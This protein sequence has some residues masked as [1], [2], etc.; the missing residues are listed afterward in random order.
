MA[1]H[2]SIN[3][4]Y[5]DIYPD[6]ETVNVDNLLADIPTIDALVLIS[7]YTAML[8]T[9]EK[10]NAIQ[11]EIV[12]AWYGRFPH[13]IKM[14][15]ERQIARDNGPFSSFNYFNNV[16]SSLLVQYLLAHNNNRY[17]KSL[18]PLQEENLFKAYL[19]FSSQWTLEQNEFQ[20]KHED[21]KSMEFITPLM[22]RYNDMFEF[23]DFR[24]QFVKA[25]YFFKFCESNPEF[26]GYL[27]AFL[28]DR[29]FEN[30]RQYLINIL[31]I[32]VH[33]LQEGNVRSVLV[34]KEEDKAVKE[35]LGEYYINEVEVKIDPDFKD[36]RTRP[37]FNLTKDEILLFN[38]NFFI[39]KLYNSILFDFGASLVRQKTKRNGE[40]KIIKSVLEFMGI[41]G[42]VFAET[43]LFYEVI[44]QTFSN[45]K[46]KKFSGDRLKALVGDGTPDFMIRDNHKLFVFEFKNLLFSAP[47][48]LSYDYNAIREEV[49]K[50]LVI[51]EEGKPKGVSQLVNTIADIKAGRYDGI[52]D[53]AYKDL[54]IYP[55]IV[56]TDFL[57][58]THGINR[59][60]E[61]EFYSQLD[62]KK[63]TVNVKSLTLIDLDL[64]IK[65]QDFFIDKKLTLHHCLDDYRKY[66]IKG[67]GNIEKSISFYRYMHDKTM[68]TK[69]ESPRFFMA[70]AKDIL[71]HGNP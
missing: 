71:E 1:I 70:L 23:K 5:S 37:V 65:F 24:L 38:L 14:A 56:T 4:S 44:E 60:I 54:I 25:M 31:S 16:T 21:F 68:K 17:E 62:A 36:L 11:M 43:G 61:P 26:N 63:S 13:P 7:H 53:I 50:K 47:A 29:G 34:F 55:I 52:D 32:Y 12:R 67:N 64:F 20:N 39:D 19:Y 42:D 27:Q 58:N 35:S 46:L 41:Y 51:N 10:S 45:K 66:L 15:I 33:L 59:M 40:G 18:T 22:I 3:L 6:Y 9:M 57:F 30:W 8:H 2:V 48:K 49:F 69:Y 28:V